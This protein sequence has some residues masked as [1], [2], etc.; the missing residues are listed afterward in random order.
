MLMRQPETAHELGSRGS[1]AVRERFSDVTMAE[2][3]LEVYRQWVHDP[4]A[5]DA[6]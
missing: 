3:T 2:T 1:E 4:N 6:P 5:E